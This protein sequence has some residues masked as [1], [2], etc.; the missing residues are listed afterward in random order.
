MD[1]TNTVAKAN[2]LPVN[3]QILVGRQVYLNMSKAAFA[4]FNNNRDTGH[5]ITAV[6]PQKLYTIVSVPEQIYCSIMTAKVVLDS[7]NILTII[8]GYHPTIKC[9]FLADSF[10]WTIKR[11]TKSNG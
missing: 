3:M 5:K 7:G 11:E 4:D 6:T 2:R 10:N 1:T 9:A 8:L